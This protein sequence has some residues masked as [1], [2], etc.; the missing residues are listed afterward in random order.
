MD[1]KLTDWVGET[2]D[3]DT[4]PPCAVHPDCFACVEGYCTALRIPDGRVTK[5]KKAAN[6]GCGFY[7]PIQQVKESGVRGYRRLKELGRRDL[8]NKYVN[9]L[10][11]TGAMDDEIRE[12]DLQAESFDQYRESNFNEQMDKAM[13]AGIDMEGICSWT[14]A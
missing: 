1:D 8:I 6:D 3:R 4:C 9:T 7:K 5:T 14:G 13:A 10:I 11:V 2:V 12:A